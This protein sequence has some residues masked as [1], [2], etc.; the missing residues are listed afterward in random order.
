MKKY[1]V[2]SLDPMYSPL[3]EKIANI[4]ATKKYAVA[5]CWAMK[6]YLPS[7]KFTLAT[8]IIKENKQIVTDELLH[9]ISKIESYHFA[10][11]KKVEGRNIKRDELE[12]MAAYYLGLKQFIQSKG[13]DLVLLHNDTRW[14]HAVAVMLC[15]ELKIKYLV[16]E[17]GLIRPNTT[18]IDSHGIN[19]KSNLPS[20]ELTQEP[21]EKFTVK[22]PHDSLISMSIFGIFLFIF[23]LEKML[24]TQ[25]NY[26]HNDYS[27]VKYYRRITNKFKRKKSEEN[28][29]VVSEQ[30]VLLLLQLELDSQ[31]LIYSEFANNQE[32][33]S[34]LESKCKEK[35]LELAVK[36]HPLDCKTYQVSEDTI[37]VNG[38]ISKLS[39]QAKM[40]FTVNSSAALQVMKTSTPLYLL[41]DS[42][43]NKPYIATQV[44]INSFDFDELDKIEIK[45][46]NRDNFL[47]LINYNYLLHGAGF[48]FNN[49]LLETKLKEL[50]CKPV[51]SCG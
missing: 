2:L 39:E 3:H 21:K 48:S 13:I 16:T 46:S 30:S 33:I 15:K 36:K 51:N 50:L 22:H 7:F 26:F 42:V 34:K 37:F 1:T 49:D 31:L 40:V 45:K 5:S 9:K 35:G 20:V 41:G 4:V 27:F 25:I 19:F 17:Q 32:L 8:K 28:K 12:Y 18:V 14:Y 11:V 47:K 43:Y 23:M 38:V 6:V 10:Y 44:D 24:K 29:G